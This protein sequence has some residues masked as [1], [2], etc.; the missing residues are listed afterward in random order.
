MFYFKFKRKNGIAT[1]EASKV[2]LPLIAPNHTAFAI[3]C[4]QI[5]VI[6]LRLTNGKYAIQMQNGKGVLGLLP[7]LMANYFLNLETKKQ[8][9]SIM[10]HV[11]NNMDEA[12]EKN[13]NYEGN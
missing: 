9:G 11:Y 10:R 13:K 8:E 3:M 12:R 6:R 2:G 1:L 4:N 5:I 7:I